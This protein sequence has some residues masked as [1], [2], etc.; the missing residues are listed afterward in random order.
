MAWYSDFDYTPPASTTDG[1]PGSVGGG[2]T[3]VGNAWARSAY[4]NIY[5]SEANAGSG[6]TPW[7][8]R[9]LVRKASAEASVNQKIQLRGITYGPASVW[10][11]ARYAAPNGDA[12]NNCYIIN[13]G[14][15]APIVNGVL[16]NVQGGSNTG[17]G[18]ANATETDIEVTVTQTNSTTTTITQTTWSVTS[19][20]AAFGSGAQISTNTYTDTTSALQNASGGQGLFAYLAS[21][22]TLFL[23]HFTT[24]T[25]VAPASAGGGTTPAPSGGGATLTLTGPSTVLSPY[26]WT[27]GL[28]GDAARTW[29][30]GAYARFFV[31]GSTSGTI[32]FGA[33][34][35]NMYASLQIDDNAW[36][37]GFY[38]SSGGT[39]NVT[40]PD[41]GSHV[42]TV[43]L[44]VIGQTAGRW[45]GS[46]AFTITSYVCGSGGVGASAVRAS[47]NVLLFGDSIWE[48]IQADNGSDNYLYDTVFF[49]GETLR[50]MGYEYGNVSCGYS[51]YSVPVPSANGGTPAGF[52]P[53]NDGASA[54]NKLDGTGGKR[55]TGSGAAERFV[56]QPDIIIDE[57]GTNDGLQSA[58]SSTLQSS[59][60]GLY[61]ALRSAAPNA[62]LLKVVPYG[63]YKRADINAAL[64]SLPADSKRQVIDLS[65]DQRQAD[66]GGVH[67]GR[68]G[69][70]QIA[71]MVIARVMSAA[72]G[73]T[74]IER[75]WA[76]S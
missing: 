3:D 36:M 75:R 17:G 60:A 43:M 40:L 37:T 31:T 46:N 35:A 76:H 34:G 54:W 14:Q 7:N 15:F 24:F 69:H 9:Q 53:G 61:A 4:N 71:P 5:V 58:A 51:G 25:D 30:T 67:P 27:T 59:I 52:V 74:G 73:G 12:T 44:I 19:N 45:D 41:A 64:A 72:A 68:T 10:I 8:N 21:G 50:R 23:D 18:F 1:G 66:Y 56:P 57:W 62:L 32:N 42:V 65:V 47:R 2:W 49:I 29:H 16:G 39:I 26:N 13:S 22:Q 70:A 63:G 28:S 6:G 38:V 11:V 33:C 48:G 55:T 20:T